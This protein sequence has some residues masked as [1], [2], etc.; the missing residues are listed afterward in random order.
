MKRYA[1]LLALALAAL[2]SAC[3][4]EAETA[5]G[6]KLWFGP[7]PDRER[8]PAAYA[9]WP[10]REEETVPGLMAALLDGPP[11][12]SGLTPIIPDGVELLDWSTEGR[13]VWV[14]LSAPY[15][16]LSGVD[17]TL[18]DYSI[19]LTLT[20]LEGV[21]GVRITVS[22]GGQ[23]FQDRPASY[24]SDVIF[25]GAEEEPVE[26]TARLWFLQDGAEELVSERRTLRLT[27]DESPAQAV[28]EALIAGP[29]EEGR[30]A[31]LPE[32]LRVNSARVD[33]GICTVDL[34]EELMSAAPGDPRRQELIVGSIVETL[35]SLDQVEQVQILIEGE[36]PGR[37]GGLDLSGPLP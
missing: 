32:D 17:L 3:G 29:E 21:D 7:D 22:G 20:Q 23:A 12:E 35:C 33:G 8:L 19:V 4:T 13:V 25:S 11:A 1:I 36:A 10:Y 15:A 26:V 2:L 24:P 5:P 34:S 16:G 27:E 6:L 37:L 28:L 14:E 9:E 31:L 30:S 18:A